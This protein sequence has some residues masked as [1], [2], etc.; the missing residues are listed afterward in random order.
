MTEADAVY[1]RTQRDPTQESRKIAC[2][3][4]STLS[5]M[6][7]ATRGEVGPKISL[8][9]FRAFQKDTVA[10][11]DL[12]DAKYAAKRFGLDFTVFASYGPGSE[13]TAAERLELRDEGAILPSSAFDL[14]LRNRY[15]VIQ[16]TYG[17]L[18]S[19]WWRDQTFRGA[20][21]CA[22]LGARVNGG[23]R[24]V[25]WSDPLDTKARWMRW[26]PAV[27]AAQK[28]A[29][30]ERIYISASPIRAPLRRAG[31]RPGVLWFRYYRSGGVWRRERR[32]TPA[33]FSGECTAPASA[34]VMGSTRRMVQLLSGVYAGSYLDL[35]AFGTYYREVA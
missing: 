22:L 19:S 26:E 2:T 14:L 11:I 7:A 18:P 15:L 1:H 25:L 8:D 24:E 9:Q 30:G 6:A 3:I 29:G 28:Y 17:A 4:A 32:W 5:C 10:G 20:H 35:G 33:G 23:I 21:A 27:A 12:Y 31:V 16:L 13:Y 34:P